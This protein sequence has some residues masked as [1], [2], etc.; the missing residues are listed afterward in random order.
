MT[1]VRTPSPFDPATLGPV[2]VPNRIIKA[3][4]SEGRSPEGLVT[5]DLIDFH[6]GFVRG[7]VGMTTIAYCCVSPEGKS[8]PG[9]IVMSPEAVPGLRRLADAVHAEGAAVSAQ[10]GHAGPVGSKKITGVT[11][12]SPSKFINP[13]SFE[14][15][16][17]I[18]RGEIAEVI[19]QFA[20]AAQVAVDAGLDAVELHFG[21]NYLP[22]AFLSPLLNRRKDEY[23]GDIDNRSRL[24]REIAR[25]VRERVGDAIAVTAKISMIDGVPGGIK[26]AESLR[27]AQLLDADANL[28]AILLTQGS[29][30]VRQMF[31]FRGDVP[32]EDFAAL[33]KQPVKTGVRLFGKK[34]LGEFPYEDLYMLEAARQFIP[35]VKNSKLILLGGITNHDHME[36]GMREG[37]DFLAMGRGLLREPGLVN[38]VREDHGKQTL[39]THCNRCMYTV[40]GRT[41]CVLDPESAYGPVATADAGGANGGAAGIPAPPGVSV[42]A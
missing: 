36:T 2:R 4:T 41:H 30:V 19:E 13:T 24:V 8:A 29:S 31:L 7:G 38:A 11:P 20:A 3:A 34:V 10:L 17:P 12:T 42:R 35:V 1:P 39:C 33:M 28:D 16:R 22:S 15:C 27:T 21:H 23:G 25:A 40:Y 9:Q 14:Y 6:L 5:Q 37:F 18:T 32:V 26:L